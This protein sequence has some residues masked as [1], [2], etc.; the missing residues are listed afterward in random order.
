MIT[1]LFRCL[2]LGLALLGGVTSLGAQSLRISPQTVDLGTV[3]LKSKN[4]MTVTCYNESDRPVVIRDIETDCVCTKPGWK[5]A[6]IMPGDSTQVTV[7]FTPTDP[8][9]FYKSIRF[10]TA[11]EQPRK[12]EFVFRGKIN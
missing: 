9:A 7:V 2:A 12:L 6:P 3:A 4:R 10:V 8:G 5:K 11:P 1:P